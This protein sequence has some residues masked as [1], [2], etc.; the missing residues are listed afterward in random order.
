[1][2]AKGQTKTKVY[3]PPLEGGKKWKS[4]WGGE[5][6]DGGKDVEVESPL[7]VMPVFERV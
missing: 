4:F 5:T 6:W 2:L 1:V 3:L 7:E